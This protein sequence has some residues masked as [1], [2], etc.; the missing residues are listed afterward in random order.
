MY[1]TCIHVYFTCIHVYTREIH[2]LHT[3]EWSS[4]VCHPQEPP[5]WPFTHL[6]VTTQSKVTIK[7]ILSLNHVDTREI[8][9]SATWKFIWPINIPWNCQH[10]SNV[11]Y[12]CRSHSISA[13]I[14]NSYLN[15]SRLHQIDSISWCR[16]MGNEADIEEKTLFNFSGCR[17][18]CWKK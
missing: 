2:M 13:N 16:L 12:I 1:F 10:S 7:E 15:I 6:L 17:E 11:I 18:T 14:K 3:W 5:L 8:H 9:M 4:C